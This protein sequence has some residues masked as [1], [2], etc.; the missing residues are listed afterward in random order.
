[1]A[2]EVLTNCFISI[3]GNDISDHVK[4]VQ[5]TYE[6]E[7]QDASTYGVGT[8]KNIGGLKNWSVQLEALNDYASSE[9]DSIVFP[10][11]G[12]EVAVILRKDAGSV[13]TT[14]PNY[15]GQAILASYNPMNG[16]VGDLASTPITLNCAGTLSRATS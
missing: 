7:M 13:A 12:T 5:L 2:V 14:N 1:M 9:L 11:V 8:R 15:T 16:S 4:S 3:A 10:L 6:A